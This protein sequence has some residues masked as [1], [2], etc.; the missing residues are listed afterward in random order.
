M[1]PELSGIENIIRVGI[2]N[3][4]SL[5]AAK[6]IVNDVLD[7]AELGAYAN[8]PV[9]IYSTGMQAR[10]SFG[11]ATALTPEILLVDEVIGVG[12]EA[13]QKRAEVRINNMIDR[14]KILFLASH[15]KDIIQRYCN[16]TITLE[17]GTIKEHAPSAVFK[18]L[19]ETIYT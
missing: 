17:A 8:L 3:G 1:N 15:S 11:V 2:Y 9:K 16:Q 5:R 4:L 6:S 19:P 18:T 14:V 7:F 10:L 12:D 13:F